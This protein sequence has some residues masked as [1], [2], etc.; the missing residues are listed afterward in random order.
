MSSRILEGRCWHRP[1]PP[2]RRHMT[3]LLIAA[4]DVQLL[5]LD[6]VETAARESKRCAQS[7][8]RDY[9]ARTRSA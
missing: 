4:R 2:H 8:M 9:I 7:C 1:R 3:A 5:S 6:I